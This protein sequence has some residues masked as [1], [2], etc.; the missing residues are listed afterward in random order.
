VGEEENVTACILTGSRAFV[1]QY[2]GD[3]ENLTTLTYLKETIRHLTALV[4]VKVEAVSCDLHPQFAT[5]LLAQKLAEDG[6]CPLTQVQHHQAHM[7]SVMGEH[8]LSEIVGVVCDGYGYGADGQAWGG[9]VLHCYGQEFRRLGHLQEQPV[10]GGDLA[11][12]Y[13]LRMAAGI[14]RGAEG[15]EEWLRANHASFPRGAKEVEI[16]TSQLGKV[17]SSTTT[18]CGRVLDAVAAILGVCRERTYQ[19]EPAIKLESAAIRGRPSFKVVPEVRGHVLSTTTLV[20]AIYDARDRYSATDLAYSAQSYLA[21]GLADLAVDVAQAT[22]VKAV[23]FSGGVAF[24]Q[25]IVLT[26]RKRVEAEGFTFYVHR[27]L[28]PGDGGVSLGQALHVACSD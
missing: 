7:L 23:G 6:G 12:K 4:N 28:P 18:S 10:I 26:L 13:P 21:E 9:E 27:Q 15:V 11:T 8:G 20:E 16:L 22:G 25:H 1:S 2:V 24:N 17:P 19:G 5:T 14:L 3:V